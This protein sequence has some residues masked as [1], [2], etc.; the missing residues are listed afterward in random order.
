[1][2]NQAQPHLHRQ[3]QIFSRLAVVEL[4]HEALQGVSD[5]PQEAPGNVNLKRNGPARPNNLW[6]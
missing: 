4:Q 2:P 1:M 3:G 6:I 5:A